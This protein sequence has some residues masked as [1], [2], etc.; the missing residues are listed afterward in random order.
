MDPLTSLKLHAKISVV[1]LT[2]WICLFLYL[3]EVRYPK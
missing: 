2:E 1:K 3:K